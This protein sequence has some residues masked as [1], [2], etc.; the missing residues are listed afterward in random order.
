MALFSVNE[1]GAEEL[2]RL[3]AR[4]NGG[5]EHI[6]EITKEL[7]EAFHLYEEGLGMYRESV[8]DNISM[9]EKM[10]LDSAGAVRNLAFRLQE[11]AREILLALYRTDFTTE[12]KREEQDLTRGRPRS[13]EK[14]A[15]HWV[16]TDD[17]SNIYGNPEQMLKQLSRNQGFVEG[18][19]GTCGIICCENVL[20]MAGIRIT[21]QELITYASNHQQEYEDGSIKRDPLCTHSEDPLQN[22]ETN[23]KDRKAILEHFGVAV[24]ISPQEIHGIAKAVVEGRGVIISV[25]SNCL[26]REEPG[27]RGDYHAVNV[28]GV[29]MKK[30]GQLDG[31]YVCDPAAERYKEHMGIELPIYY[32]A[33]RIQKSLSEKPCMITKYIIR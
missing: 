5:H 10:T 11:A 22:G 1:E 3:A 9:L 4:V 32:K 24:D 7:K 6:N 29:K 21:Q 19:E 30:D 28:I 20:K 23:Y 12:V 18:F 15:L 31:F 33:E 27:T 16:K 13:L 26:Y 14:T 25:H 2:R 17:G 8:E